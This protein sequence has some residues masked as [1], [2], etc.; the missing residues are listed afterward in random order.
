MVNGTARTGWWNSFW[1]PT[2]RMS[3]SDSAAG[4]KCSFDLP[5]QPVDLASGVATVDGCLGVESATSV[6]DVSGSPRGTERNTRAT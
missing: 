5:T 1:C 2:K 3:G 4:E 6:L